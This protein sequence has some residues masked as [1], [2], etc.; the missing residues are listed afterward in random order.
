MVE[1][2]VFYYL[3]LLS[4]CTVKI[5][6]TNSR[7]PLYSPG[8][9]ADGIASLT[10][11]VADLR[12]EQS[13]LS[14]FHTDADG[15][16]QQ[17]EERAYPTSDFASFADMANK[18]LAE[19]N[20]EVQRISV[21]VPGPV[22]FGRCE[23]VHLP[24]ALDCQ[25]IK[26][27]LKV[28]RVHLINDMEAM[29]YSLAELEGTE[30]VPIHDTEKVMPGNVA[31]L[32]PGNGLGEAGLFWDGSALRPFATE[33]GHTE[34]S[35]RNEFEVEF[36]QFLN[37]IYG[38]VSWEKILSKD[39]IYNIYR[40]LRDIGRHTED[41]AFSDRINSGADFLDELCSV[42][43]TGS[44]RLVNT[45]LEMYAELL[46]REANYLALKL[47]ATGGL[48]ISGEV[49]EKVRSFIDKDK[50]YADFKFSDKME[51]LLKEIPIYFMFNSKAILKGAAYY[52]AVTED[53]C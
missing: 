41:R 45:T 2:F 3:Y 32:A 18:Y 34:F 29:A 27:T 7:F 16:L 14:L 15:K 24:W 33:G 1:G 31:I 36:Y 20:K 5:M 35:P 10:I 44:S 17:S 22:I 50:F 42:G 13:I 37:K 21:G 30:M 12:K 49:T 8:R 40:F 28:E 9:S 39:G 23:T 52:G 43:A 53:K 11:L 6:N 4:N 38:I 46:A 47:K 25:E 26:Q 48:I 51:H 19:T